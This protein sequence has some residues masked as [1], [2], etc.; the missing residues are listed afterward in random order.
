MIGKIALFLFLM[1]LESWFLDGWVFGVA[2]MLSFY[3]VFRTK[4]QETQDEGA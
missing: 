1:F 4:K 3:L 2:L